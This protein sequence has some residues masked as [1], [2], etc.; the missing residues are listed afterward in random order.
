MRVRTRRAV[1]LLAIVLLAATAATAWWLVPRDHV[2]PAKVTLRTPG[3]YAGT[4]AYSPDGQY[5]AAG[6]GRA[7]IVWDRTT[8]QQVRT[9]DHPTSDYV[10]S[11]AYSPDGGMLAAGCHDGHLAVSDAGRGERRLVLQEGGD[12]QGFD[13]GIDRSI[14]AVRFSPDGRT[15]AA[16]HHP[17]GGS[18]TAPS[19]V[20]LWDATSGKENLVLKDPHGSETIGKEK[21]VPRPYGAWVKS[22]AFSHEGTL[23]A[24]AGQGGDVKL[25]NP[26]DGS[27]RRDLPSRGQAVEAV[28]FAPKGGIVA[29]GGYWSDT[30]DVATLFDLTAGSEGRLRGQPEEHYLTYVTS[31]AFSPDGRTLATGELSKEGTMKNPDLV[32]LWDVRT[33]RPIGVLR[34]DRRS[35]VNAVAFSPDGSELAAACGNGIPTE[36]G[37]VRVWDVPAR[38]GGAE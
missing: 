16:A 5:L 33:G 7:V 37:E 11:I 36:A 22:I 24:T 19:E 20:R 12:R 1:L 28:A 9:L 30:M 4:V 6:G 31:L 8:W 32:R 23:L 14:T 29:Y 15:V 21:P 34:C 18:Q 26:A 17:W 13:R 38:P 35:R 25:W 27:H 2:E 10:T 3:G